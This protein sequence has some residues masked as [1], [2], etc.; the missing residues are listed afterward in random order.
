MVPS[1]LAVELPQF[2][3]E[4]GFHRYYES[5]YYWWWLAPF[6]ESQYYLHL[7]GSHLRSLDAMGV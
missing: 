1:G 3:D 4:Q 5:Y 2:R 6:P 7:P